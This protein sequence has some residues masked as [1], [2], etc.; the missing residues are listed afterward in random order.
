MLKA[1]LSS[2]FLVLLSMFLA[3]CAS[4]RSPTS[5][6]QLALG[7]RIY[8]QHCASCHGAKGEG[9]YPN[10]PYK[11]DKAGLIGAPPHDSTGHT[12]HHPDGV[13][14]EI[15]RDGLIV[16]GFQPMPAFGDKLTDAGMQAVLTYIKTWWKPEQVERQATFS[17]R[18]TPSAQ[19]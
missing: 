14:L 13:L 19:K 2:A 5:A 16:E 1:L 11:P 3:R 7:K 6:D 15:I 17:A 18:Y 9:Q 10:A 12:W 8:D 4:D